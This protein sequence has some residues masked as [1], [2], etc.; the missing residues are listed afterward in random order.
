MVNLKL[1]KLACADCRLITLCLPRG[2]DRE[3]MERLDGIVKRGPPLQ[4]GQYL[5]RQG[6]PMRWLFAVRAGSLRVFT[7]TADG[8]EQTVGF[9]LLGEVL[10]FD[11]LEHERH[12]CTAVALETTAVCELPLDR[13]EELCG[14]LPRLQ[15]QLLSLVGKEIASEHESIL[16]LA[17]RSAEERLATFLLSLSMRFGERGLSRTEFN[18]SMSRHDIANFLGV[19]AET[20]SRQLSSF[21]VQGILS[22]NQRSVQIHDLDRL[23]AFVEPCL[24]PTRLSGSAEDAS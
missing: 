9:Y 6:D 19:A 4:R 12:T 2:L 18:L 11:G 20:V 23:R 8:T 13:L 21:Q 24:T 15:H 5:Y 3:D 16:S 10:G 7:S 14:E 22:V 1:L 17:T